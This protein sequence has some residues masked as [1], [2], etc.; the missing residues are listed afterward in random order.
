MSMKSVGASGGTTLFEPER[1][2]DVFFVNAAVLRHLRRGVAGTEATHDYI[3]TNCHTGKYRPTKRQARIDDD[4]FGLFL[5]RHRGAAKREQA[6]R[7]A[8][9]I[10]FNTGERQLKIAPQCFLTLT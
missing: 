1:F 9:T 4:D 10:P 2:F 3:G 5:I 6:N 8:L 7:G